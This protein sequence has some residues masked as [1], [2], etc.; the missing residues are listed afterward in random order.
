MS[1]TEGILIGVVLAIMIAL[2]GARIFYGVG[3]S[4]QVT[5]INRSAE[6]IGEARLSQ[7]DRV[8][9]LVQIE[10]GQMRSA[11]F[12]AREGSLT[13]SVTFTSGRTL[14]ADNVGYVTASIPVTVRFDIAGDKVALL[15]IIHRSP[16]SYSKR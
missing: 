4:S 5:L 3:L 6:T 2:A 12:I 1:W 9:T 11:D 14:S 10:P 15:H 13:L 16:N 7:G 8:T